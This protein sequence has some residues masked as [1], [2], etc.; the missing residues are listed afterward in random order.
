MAANLP[1]SYTCIKFVLNQESEIQ[2]MKSE[3][4]KYKDDKT[5]M[6]LEFEI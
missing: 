2:L 4:E 1:N 3:R 5:R 6:E